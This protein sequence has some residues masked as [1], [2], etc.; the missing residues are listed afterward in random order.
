MLT[1]P[2]F[3]YAMSDMVGINL[4]SFIHGGQGDIAGKIAQ[5]IQSALAVPLVLWGAAPFFVRGW[6]SIK[7]R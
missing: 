1:V 2:L 7:S 6:Q 4:D 5:W 3:L